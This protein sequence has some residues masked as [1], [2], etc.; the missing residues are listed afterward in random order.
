MNLFIS[1][2]RDDSYFANGLLRELKKNPRFQVWI[3]SQIP[4]GQD[5]WDTIL[6]AVDWCDCCIF[7]MS[8]RSVDSIYCEAEI[9]YVLDWH[10]PILPLLH[11]ACIVPRQ[12]NENRVQY[13]NV[14]SIYD[15][16]EVYVEVAAALVEV[17]QNIRDGDYAP[18]KQKPNRPP[19]PKNQIASDTQSIEIKEPKAPPK[20]KPKLDPTY[21]IPPPFEWIEIPAGKVTLGGNDGANGGYIKN[22]TTFDV[23]AFA[24]AK[25]PITNRQ[26]AKFIEASG[27]TNRNWWTPDGWKVREKEGWTEPRYWHESPWNTADHPVV[28]V[29]WYEAVAFCLWLSEVTG[30]NIMLPT[31]QQWQ[32]AAQA[33]D[34]RA[35]PWGNDWGDRRCNNRVEPNVSASTT[36]VTQFEEGDEGTSPFGVADM[37]GNV[38]EWCL[39]N[40]ETGRN[41]IYETNARILRGGS[42]NSDITILLLTTYRNFYS[43]DYEYNDFGFRLARS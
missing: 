17:L 37:A 1:Y 39:T 3:D 30:E 26:F 20:P 9:S 41:D 24:I 28:G 29:T 33:D 32:R 38:W 22:A 40:Y 34:G 7:I 2:S 27:Y 19:V 36:L 4:G 23:P 31:E 35:Y 18:P 14:T 15:P 12:L 10:K 21:F 16:R 11:K 43:P 13:I 8:Q 6:D 42:W 5:W 25:Y